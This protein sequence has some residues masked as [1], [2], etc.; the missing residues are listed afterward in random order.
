MM[1]DGRLPDNVVRLPVITRLDLDP[2][3]VL[4]Q[5][6]GEFKSVIVIGYGHDG[7]ER[8]CA[9]M[10]DGPEMLWLLA[11]YQKKLLE[12]PETWDGETH[13]KDRA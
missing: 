11:R 7:E 2:D 4:R 1:D 10:S 9:S 8:C 13:P 3:L 5:A 12:I 6:I